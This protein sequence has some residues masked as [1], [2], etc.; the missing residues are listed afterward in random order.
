M[1]QWQSLPCDSPVALER[2]LAAMANDDCAAV[3]KARKDHPDLVI[4]QQDLMRFAVQADARKVV[5]RLQGNGVD[6]F[7]PDVQ[8]S[9]FWAALSSRKYDIALDMLKVA[10]RTNDRALPDLGPYLELA[11]DNNDRPAV[12]WLL[13]FSLERRLDMPF[14]V[15]RKAIDTSNV[16]RIEL[17]VG[18]RSLSDAFA[19]HTV[20]R[21]I[22]H[23]AIRHGS[24]DT[25]AFLLN[26]KSGRERAAS[27]CGKSEKTGNTA[28]HVAVASGE[29]A[30]LTLVLKMHKQERLGRDAIDTRN[31]KNQPAL[32]LALEAG[33]FE[34]ADLLL[35]R[36]AKPLKQA[37][38]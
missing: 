13:K 26:R 23:Y 7:G 19:N 8:A 31:A 37:D 36:G 35:S 11:L 5:F 17:L 16:R 32:A 10:F 20:E 1:P 15:L 18:H 12:S 25:V 30:K 24:V 4:A 38:I 3:E 14:E 27:L 33:H 22:L 28:L 6:P 2:V 21:S 29:V 9:T 34:A